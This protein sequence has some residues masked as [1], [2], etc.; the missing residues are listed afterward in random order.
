MCER[1]VRSHFLV[2]LIPLDLDDY[3][4][5]V[6]LRQL[7]LSYNNWR[8]VIHCWSRGSV[9]LDRVRVRQ[10]ALY[11]LPVMLFSA[12]VIFRDKN[13]LLRLSLFILTSAWSFSVVS[14][15]LCTHTV[16]H[17]TTK[18][19]R[20]GLTVHPDLDIGRVHTWDPVEFSDRVGMSSRRVNNPA[21]QTK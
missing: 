16:W 2:I 12:S 1:D 11:F 9:R 6:C 10:D 15:C 20:M 18:V 4:R 14:P 19:G 5:A 7:T 13:Y 3:W 17:K 8:I 21:V